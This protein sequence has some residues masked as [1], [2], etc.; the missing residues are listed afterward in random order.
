M[1]APAGRKGHSPKEV[2][3][4]GPGVVATDLAT[5]VGLELEHTFWGP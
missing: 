2:E 5:A 3:L 4:G 1:L